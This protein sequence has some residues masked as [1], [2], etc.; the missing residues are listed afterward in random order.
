MPLPP[1]SVALP[2]H[3]ASP[4]HLRCAFESI[5]RQ[6]HGDLEILLVLNGA[7]AAT[8]GLVESLAASDPRARVLHLPAAGL[9]AA[10]NLALHEARH[11]LVA[12]MDGDDD[13]PPVRLAHQ[14]DYLK[15]NP[16]IA[17]LGTAWETLADGDKSLGVERPPTDPAEVRWR[18]CLGNCLCHGSVMVWR[19]TVLGAGGYD[20]SLP[21]AQDYDLWLRLSR[22]A[23]LANLPQA[24]YRYRADPARRHEVQAKGAAAAM[25]RHWAAL[26]PLADPAL[27]QR[28]AGI[29]W[30]ATWG[31]ARARGAQ[32]A[33][34]RFLAQRGPSPQAL[35]AYQWVAQRAGPTALSPEEL[36]KLDRLREVGRR[37]RDAGV[38]AVWL[39]GA[40]KHTAWLM[41]N[42]DALGLEVRGLADDTLAGDRHHGFTVVLPAQIPP[43]THVL[44]SSDHHEERLWAASA[45]LRR[46]GVTVWRLY[47]RG[48]VAVSSSAI[49]PPG[50]SIGA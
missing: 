12:R 30:E 49:S 15:T 39:Y 20:E 4:L 2:V 50:V 8:I 24:L 44:L 21:Y 16:R 47:T 43:S 48:E 10:L 32:A 28:L 38:P 11:D 19:P 45:A 1:V 42:R 31:G 27:Q 9:A 37:L 7:D 36:Q 41:E 22:T 17:A 13:C 40:G 5:T 33:L 46:R 26:P 25:V 35:L 18:L 34:E 3:R 14:A 29:V 6:T 23:E